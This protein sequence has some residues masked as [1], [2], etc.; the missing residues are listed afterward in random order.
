MS[1]AAISWYH[2]AR[3]GI[4]AG[5]AAVEVPRIHLLFA[6]ERL[7]RRQ[8]EYALQGMAL[9]ALAVTPVDSSTA[10]AWRAK[11]PRTSWQ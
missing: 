7:D 11:W 5:H 2:A 3:S 8:E 4:V 10:W 1:S 6:N 9:I